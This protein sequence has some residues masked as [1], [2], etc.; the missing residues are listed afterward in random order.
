MEQVTQEGRDSDAPGSTTSEIEELIAATDESG[1]AASTATDEK[2]KQLKH[3]ELEIEKAAARVRIDKLQ[4]FLGVEEAE[5][6]KLIDRAKKDALDG[7]S[8]DRQEGKNIL[9]IADFLFYAIMTSLLVY[10]LW[11]DY[12]INVLVYVDKIFPRE[13]ETLRQL[14]ILPIDKGTLL[15]SMTTV[16]VQRI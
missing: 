2:T 1:A 12:G 7:K 10:Y 6:K 11:K 8:V 4:A 5:V 15:Q 3:R 13:M 9:R 16:K 14:G